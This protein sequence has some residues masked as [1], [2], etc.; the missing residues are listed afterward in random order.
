M[1]HL[2][3]ISS[4]QPR[5]GL[6]QL[7]VD[8]SH[9][10]KEPGALLH[11]EYT[12]I[13]HCRADVS[14]SHGQVWPFNSWSM[15]RRDN[16]WQTLRLLSITKMVNNAEKFCIACSVAYSYPTWGWGGR[17]GR[18]WEPPIFQKFSPGPLMLIT[19]S[20]S[21][22]R[23]TDSCLCRASAIWLWLTKPERRTTCPIDFSRPLESLNFFSGCKRAS[24]SA[25][26][27]CNLNT[28]LSVTLSCMCRQSSGSR[29]TYSFG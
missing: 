6:F 22:G 8:N 29:S 23:N 18:P 2:C 15:L 5:S 25:F 21:L 17:L 4:E 16:I 24:L 3:M 11:Q 20:L 14:P 26:H 27:S 7:N 19:S 28:R 10:L 13:A 1:S 12:R 9:A